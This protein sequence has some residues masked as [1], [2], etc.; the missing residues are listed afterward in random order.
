MAASIEESP[1]KPAFEND[2]KSCQLSSPA[3]C[4]LYGNKII[5]ASLF[6][7]RVRQLAGE[8]YTAELNERECILLRERE[9]INWNG[10]KQAIKLYLCALLFL[11]RIAIYTGERARSKRRKEKRAR[12]CA[13]HCHKENAAR[14]HFYY[15]KFTRER[16]RVLRIPCRHKATRRHRYLYI[17][18][19]ETWTFCGAFVTCCK[20]DKIETV[21]KA[22]GICIKIHTKLWI[23]LSKDFFN[24]KQ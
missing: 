9:R 6:Q 16:K 4:E 2:A 21:K 23:S 18:E 8:K 11:G 5:S 13:D 10:K 7:K 15:F 20:L 19:T 14:R 24:I 3:F 1:Q 12:Q 22:G 17:C